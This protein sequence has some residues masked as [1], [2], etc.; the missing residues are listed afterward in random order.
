M[1]KFITKIRNFDSFGGCIPTF[2][3]NKH[4]ILHGGAD[5]HAKFH[6]YQGNVSPPAGRKTYFWT[7]E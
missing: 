4:E 2:L 3:P 5:P 1:G 6:V 7:T